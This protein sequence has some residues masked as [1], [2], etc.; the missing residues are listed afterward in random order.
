MRLAIDRSFRVELDIREG[1]AVLQLVDQFG[2]PRQGAH[3]QPVVEEC[4]RFQAESAQFCPQ[5]ERGPARDLQH[6]RARV[7]GQ[8]GAVKAVDG[9]PLLPEGEPRVKVNS[10]LTS[11]T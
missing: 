7:R 5:D 4:P 9:P 8:E 2:T 6:P 11:W 3:V 1:S 10:V